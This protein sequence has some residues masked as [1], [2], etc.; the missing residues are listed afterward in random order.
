MIPRM[1]LPVKRNAFICQ[2][3]GVREAQFASNQHTQEGAKEVKR[4]SRIAVAL[5]TW[6]VVAKSGRIANLVK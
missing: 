2:C 1:T 6:F 3:S 4:G 5:K